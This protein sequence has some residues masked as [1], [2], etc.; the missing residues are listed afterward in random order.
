MTDSQPPSHPASH[1]AVA[2]TLNAKASSLKTILTHS[3]S[4]VLF[5]QCRFFHCSMLPLCPRNWGGG[6]TQIWGHAKISGALCHSLC[7]QLQ[8]RVSAFAQNKLN[9]V[10]R[11]QTTSTAQSQ[12]R[13]GRPLCRLQFAGRRLTAAW[14]DLTN[15]QFT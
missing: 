9:A 4:L 5:S 2:I 3:L 1:V 11:T 15:R 10:V 6:T 7:S 8:N 12:V 14:R 13:L